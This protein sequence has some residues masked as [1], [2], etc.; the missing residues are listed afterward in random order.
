[1][2][3]TDALRIIAEQQANNDPRQRLLCAWLRGIVINMTEEEW[4]AA[5][6]R[7]DQLICGKVELS[8]GHP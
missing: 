5:V 3:K 6:N 1:M 2:K 8:D 7:H 4:S